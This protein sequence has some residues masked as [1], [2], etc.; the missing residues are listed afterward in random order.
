MDGKPPG[1]DPS[2]RTAENPLTPSPHKPAIEKTEVASQP[3]NVTTSQQDTTKELKREFKLFEILSLAVNV[4][5]A[6]VGVGALCIYSG[7]LEVMRGTL[8]EVKRG[9][10]VATDQ[11]WRAIRNLNWIA[12][13][14]DG[15]LTQAQRSLNAS[16]K[17]TRNEQRAWVGA[18]EIITP[19]PTST[20][21]YGVWITNTGKTP[22]K[23][24][25]AKISTQY[26]PTRDGDRPTFR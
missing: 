13:T 22:A 6:L 24:V 26:L 15:T 23:K 10:S 8:A 1:N 5:L 21:H 3:A 20:D 7:Q 11:T 9:G 18:I 19:T 16:I 4:V 12:R 17:M 2:R 25:F 14:M